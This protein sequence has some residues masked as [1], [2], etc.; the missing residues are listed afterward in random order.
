[1]PRPKGTPKTGG[2]KKGSPAKK[3]ILITDFRS[4][5]EANGLDLELQLSQAILD[6]DVFLIKALTGVL[7]YLAPRLKEVEKKPPPEEPIPDDPEAEAELI[8]LLRD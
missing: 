7:P 4:R 8:K 5:L 2:R 3:A 6:E 1:M